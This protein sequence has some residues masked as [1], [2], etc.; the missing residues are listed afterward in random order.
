MV[1]ELAMTGTAADAWLSDI[2]LGHDAPLKVLLIALSP[3]LR[4]VR[5]IRGLETIET[6]SMDFDTLSLL[7]NAIETTSAV[8]D[9]WNRAPGFSSVQQIAVGLSTRAL[10]SYNELIAYEQQPFEGTQMPHVRP[11]FLLPGLK[12]LYIYG[13]DDETTTGET[14]GLH[15]IEPSVYWE[16]P[17]GCSPIEE[18]CFDSPENP[19]TDPVQVLIEACGKLKHLTFMNGSMARSVDCEYLLGSTK[20]ARK[21]KTL[22]SVLWCGTEVNGYRSDMYDPEGYSDGYPLLTMSMDDIIPCGWDQPN[23]EDVEKAF[24]E[25]VWELFSNR[26]ARVFITHNM[27]SCSKELLER[28]LLAAVRWRC[29]DHASCWDLDEN[30]DDEEEDNTDEVEGGSERGDDIQK[31]GSGEEDGEEKE[32]RLPCGCLPSSGNHDQYMDYSGGSSPLFLEGIEPWR[33]TEPHSDDD[34]E[35]GNTTAPRDAPAPDPMERPF[36]ELIRYCKLWG[37][38][39]FTRT[40][41]VPRVYK[42]EMPNIPSEKDLETSPWYKHPEVERIYLKPHKGLV[43]DCRNCGECEECYAIH[44]PEAWA[45]WKEEDAR[46]DEKRRKLAVEE[47]EAAAAAEEEGYDGYEG[48]YGGEDSE[49]GGNEG[50]EDDNRVDSQMEDVKE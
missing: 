25:F 9:G 16:L 36:G 11:F 33:H 39:I 4:A 15:N 43:E 37:V 49:D 29:W 48:E 18:L 20:M 46:L 19:Q 3:R 35:Q 22:K 30:D 14:T 24:V 26:E 47:E 31:E 17:E 34:E 27:R 5:F 23:C 50:G 8:S 44:P 2:K 40:L 10:P 38:D 13:F 21:N 12:S 28:V 7:A 41:P 6:P 45:A 42:V 1:Q 32:D